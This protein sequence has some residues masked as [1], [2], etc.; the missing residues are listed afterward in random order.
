[1]PLT[2]DSLRLYP[3]RSYFDSGLTRFPNFRIVQLRLLKSAIVKYEHEIS[4]ALFT[5]LKK[6]KEESFAAETGLIL[7]EISVALKN[8]QRWMRPVGVKTNLLNFP[9]SSRILPQPKGVVLIISP[10]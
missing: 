5:D 1:M 6:S 9:S 7:K 8:L 10:W 3:M 2:A 4:E